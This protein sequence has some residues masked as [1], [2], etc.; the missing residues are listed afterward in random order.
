MAG[1]ADRPE[2]GCDGTWKHYEV[3]VLQKKTLC[4]CEKTGSWLADPAGRR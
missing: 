1:N 2:V 4:R 3:V